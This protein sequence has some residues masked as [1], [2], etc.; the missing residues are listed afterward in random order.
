MKPNIFICG[1]S[2]TGKSSSLRNLNPDKTA[3]LNV[4]QKA[5][6]FKEANKFILNIGI[7]TLD[8]YNKSFDRALSSDKV[9]FIVHESF[10]AITESIYRDLGKRGLKGFDLW[11]E[12]NKEIDRI[13]H[14]SKTSNKYNIFLGIDEFATNELTGVQERYVKVQ[15]NVWRKSVEKEFV[16][17]AYTEVNTNEENN[18]EHR[19]I[20]NRCQGYTSISAKSPMGMLEPFMPNDL[21]LL[22]QKI[23]EYYQ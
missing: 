19:F 8:D 22:I 1:P 21:N 17:V 12:Y 6:P 9:D 18:L 13:L 4:E 7:P 16:I 23:E 2:G 14:K 15:G 5:L 3:I 11:G 10:T 20:T